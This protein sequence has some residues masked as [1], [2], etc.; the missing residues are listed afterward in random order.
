MATYVAL[1]GVLSGCLPNI[2]GSMMHPSYVYTLASKRNGTLYLGST[3]DIIKRTL[4]HKNKVILTSL[5]SITYL[6]LS[7]MKCTNYILKQ[8]VVKN[9]LK[10]GQDNEK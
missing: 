1:L 7:I 3:P 4:E 9:V 8:L 2:Q 6:C 10:I 5:L